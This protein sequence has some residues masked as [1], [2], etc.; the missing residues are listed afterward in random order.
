[1]HSYWGKFV[2]LVVGFKH[3]IVEANKY[4]VLSLENG[5]KKYLSDTSDENLF[6]VKSYLQ[7]SYIMHWHWDR[8]WDIL[9]NS[10]VKTID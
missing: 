1:M 3:L 8:T 7:Y 10:H 5:F 4:L 9:K 6:F 2:F